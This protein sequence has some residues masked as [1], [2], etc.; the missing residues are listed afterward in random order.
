MTVKAAGTTMAT[1]VLG[2]RRAA[3]NFPSVRAKRARAIALND[4]NAD[5]QSTQ[6]TGI[7]VLDE[8]GMDLDDQNLASCRPADL[9]PKDTKALRTPFP[10]K[11]TPPSTPLQSE[12]AKRNDESKLLTPQTPRHREALSKKV[13][14]TP[15]RSTGLRGKL[16]TPRASPSP[17]GSPTIY[18]EARQPFSRSAHPSRLIGREAER[19]EILSFI[20]EGI[21]A[22][23]G[24]CLYV[25]GPPGTGKSALINEICNGL[26]AN[27]SVRKANINCMSIKGAKDIY[28]KLVN[29]LGENIEE[30]VIDEV[31]HLQSIFCPK[32]KS[33]KKMFVVTMD[34]ID[35]LLS[36]DL[37]IFYSLFEWSLKPKSRLILLGIANALDLTDRFL[38]RLKARNLRP[39]LLPF[40]P[41]TAPQIELVITTK[42]KSLLP[43]GSDDKPQDFIPFVHPSAI[44]FC[45]KKVA[46][47]SGDLRKAFTLI[48]RTIDL[49]E[50]EVKRA[51]QLQLSPSKRPLSEN[52]NLSSPSRSS[53]STA[54]GL[55]SL[56]SSSAPRATIAH[57]AQISA[58]TLGNGITERLQGL[59]LQQKAVLCALA[60]REKAGGSLQVGS[61]RQTPTKPRSIGQPTVGQ[62]Y[63]TYCALCTKENALHPLTKT[64]FTDVVG[65]L[66]TL[67]LVGEGSGG[68]GFL[69]RTPSKKGIKG[70]KTRMM[71]WV[72]V[73]ELE[74]CLTG[75]GSGILKRLLA[76]RE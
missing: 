35:H 24:R 18:S 43:I 60:S 3:G 32:T 10:V 8:H 6:S 57:V 72:T 68:T 17:R 63:E 69:K 67:G 39:Q 9:L 29:D 75:P 48:H 54:S 65:G 30:A 22:M 27:S 26:E 55:A 46:A 56:T 50:K 64:E 37:D 13:P 44:Q 52:P 15:C 51:H 19:S 66:E 4:E 23:S 33:T 34:E 42:L 73:Q 40:L 28:L 20:Q 7:S 62:L 12:S 53:V 14:V 25:S 49:V 31:K 70:E 1:T 61:I 74:Q 45:S 59:N 58:A 36:L 47:Q 21:N 76:G 16:L 2:K 71:N 41:Y 5:P 11:P 38:P